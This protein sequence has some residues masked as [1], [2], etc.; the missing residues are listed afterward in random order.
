MSFV[1]ELYL[2]KD[3]VND[4][5][6]RVETSVSFNYIEYILITTSFSVN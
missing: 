5:A 6:Q 2:V 3:S 1:I 4:K